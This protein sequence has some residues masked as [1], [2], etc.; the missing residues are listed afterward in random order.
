M[1][2]K[3]K[4]G[5][6]IGKGGVPFEP[7]EEYFHE[8][9]ALQDL[10]REAI[11]SIQEVAWMH[12]RLMSFPSSDNPQALALTEDLA[13]LTT[14][15]RASFASIAARIHSLDQGNANLGALIPAGLG[16]YGLSLADVEVRNRQLAAFRERFKTV[17][18]ARLAE[19]ER[20]NRQTSRTRIERQIKIVNP[21]LT[22]SELQEVV[23]QA[24]T[25]GGALFSQAVG[26]SPRCVKFSLIVAQ[27][28]AQNQRSH[29]ARG[30]LR[31]VQ[32][33]AAE[34]SRIEE[35]LVELAQLFGDMAM[36]VESQ[37]IEVQRIEQHVVDACS[38]VEVALVHTQKAVVSARSTRKMRFVRLPIKVRADPRR[39]CCFS[40][41]ATV[42]LIILIVVI[43]EVIL[44]L[45]RKN[46][47]KAT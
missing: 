19:V 2:Q 20:D 3:R 46:S 37:D 32:S 12:T 15:L 47:Q 10:L 44:P 21:S 45:V 14:S 6:T 5:K 41:F 40:I 28:L 9:G 36:L 42:L 30:A 26:S 31:E 24:E 43:V 33:R 4:G 22:P 25:G 13:N 8:L 18:L 17:G 1:T 23:R 38:D 35:T 16:S 34:L 27:L 39:W 7:M 29:S 11:S